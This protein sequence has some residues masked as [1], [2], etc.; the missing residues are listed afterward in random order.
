MYVMIVMMVSSSDDSRDIFLTYLLTHCQHFRNT[1][2]LREKIRDQSDEIGCLNATVQRLEAEKEEMTRVASEQQTADA[3]RFA[4]LLEHAEM[5]VASESRNKALAREG[6]ASALRHAATASELQRKQNQAMVALKREMVRLIDVAT[7]AAAS[8]DSASVI[9]AEEATMTQQ[10]LIADIKSPPKSP[11]KTRPTSPSLKKSRPT[12][13]AKDRSISPSSPGKKR[14]TKAAEPEP[15]VVVESV[16]V[17]VSTTTLRPL[18]CVPPA[19]SMAF[20]YYLAASFGMADDKDILSLREMD[21]RLMMGDEDRQ[22]LIL[23]AKQ[24]LEAAIALAAAE[25]AEAAAAAL[26]AA[27]AK[28]NKAT[29]NKAGRSLSPA[30]VPVGKGS[31]AKK[32]GTATAGAKKQKGGKSDKSPSPA[33]GRTASPGKGNGA[34]QGKAGASPSPAAAKGRAKSPEKGGAKPNTSPGKGNKSAPPTKDKA[35]SVSPGKKGK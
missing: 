23:V 18:P 20:C 7:K 29:A 14:P 8:A 25:A 2:V 19:E 4:A 26:K 22:M 31:E 10:P 33:R 12:T 3:N 30:A 1:T 15:A 24:R 16:P 34:K 35:R 28:A 11:P 21:E 32:G 5:L 17:P 27:K 6:Y 13:P 9:P